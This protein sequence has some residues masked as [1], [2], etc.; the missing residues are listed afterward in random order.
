MATPGDTDVGT[1]AVIT[2]GTTGTNYVPEVND[3]RHTGIARP[4]VDVTHLTTAG[5]RSY[6]PGDLYDPGEL[7]IE[8]NFGDESGLDIPFPWTGSGGA[9]ETI[10]ITGPVAASTGQTMAASGF[11]T[12]VEYGYPLEDKVTATLMFKLSDDISWTDGA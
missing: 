12:G 8:V 1:G 11:I 10:T 4:A 6:M 9:A 3:I 5:G 7:Q 2:F